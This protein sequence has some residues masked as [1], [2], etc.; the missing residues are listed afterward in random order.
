MNELC[1]HCGGEKSFHGG[2][3]CMVCSACVSK[4]FNEGKTCCKCQKHKPFSHFF[5]KSASSDGYQSRCKSCFRQYPSV[6]AAYCD[7]VDDTAK[8]TRQ[9]RRI[10]EMRELDE[11]EL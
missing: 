2:R 10:E 5:K 9:R 4:A 1:C 8:Y 3:G 6:K 7:D 11:L